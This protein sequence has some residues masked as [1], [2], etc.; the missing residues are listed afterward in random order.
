MV[1]TNR[2]K[3]TYFYLW[4][5]CSQVSLEF[6]MRFLCFL[7]LPLIS[8]PK[9]QVNGSP[10]K[11]SSKHIPAVCSRSFL[12]SHFH[13]NEQRQEGCYFTS[14]N[15][16]RN[17]LYHTYSSS[18]VN[19]ITKLEEFFFFLKRETLRLPCQGFEPLPGWKRGLDTTKIFP[20]IQFY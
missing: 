18:H 8:P 11:S 9:Q 13:N 5:D 17:W 16:C 20:T 2:F 7:Q 14:S 1:N 4:K 19:C 10:S 12:I 6:Y 3:Y 15:S